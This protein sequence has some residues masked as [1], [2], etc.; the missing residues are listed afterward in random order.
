MHDKLIRV[1]DCGSILV[2]SPA[3]LKAILLSYVSTVHDIGKVDQVDK[4]EVD[5]EKVDYWERGLLGT[6]TW[7]GG[8]LGRW[9]IGKMDLYCYRSIS[10]TLFTFFLLFMFVTFPLLIMFVTFP[11]C[12]LKKPLRIALHLLHLLAPDETLVTRAN[13]LKVKGLSEKESKELLDDKLKELRE[14]LSMTSHVIQLFR[15]STLSKSFLAVDSD[16]PFV[17]VI[18]SISHLTLS[19]FPPKHNSH[20]R[21][22]HDLASVAK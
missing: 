1:R 2:T 20:G 22:G 15:T 13:G 19:S 6:W 3:Q 17:V 21:S 12:Q 11:V 7:E 4:V 14:E 8:L 18:W 9:I 5:L 16:G 10:N